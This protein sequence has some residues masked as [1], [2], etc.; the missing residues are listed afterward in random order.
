[1]STSPTKMSNWQGR[2]DK[3]A[4][5]LFWYFICIISSTSLT[6]KKLKIMMDRFIKNYVDTAMSLFDDTCK[7]VNSKVEN[8]ESGARIILVVPGLDKDDLKITTEDER[9]TV[10]GV[11]KENS[12][13]KVLPDFKES[14]YVGREID[15]NNISASLKNGVLLINLQKKKGLAGK[16]ITID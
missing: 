16:Q 3:K 11:N 1:M 2:D 6:K 7:R 9:L 15:M 8:T 14:F 12:E 13:T 4:E 5:K 10:S